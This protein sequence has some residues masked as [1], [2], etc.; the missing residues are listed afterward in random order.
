MTLCYE[1]LAQPSSKTLP[2]A[3]DGNKYRDWTKSREWEN[4]EHLVLM[5]CLHQRPTCRAQGTLWRRSQK[6]CKGQWRLRTPRKQSL[7]NTASS[8]DTHTNS[9]RLLWQNAM[10]CMDLCQNGVPALREVNS[11]LHPYPRNNYLRLITTCK[12]NISSL[13][14]SHWGYKPCLGFNEV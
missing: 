4:V 1:C 3:I 5:G 12:W 7:R 10:A 6:R 11:C 2:P 8:I 14:Q 13:Q 9:L